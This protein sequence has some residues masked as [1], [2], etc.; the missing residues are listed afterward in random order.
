MTRYGHKKG[1]VATHTCCHADT[2]FIDLAEDVMRDELG[3]EPPHAYLGSN[4]LVFYTDCKI[5]N[6]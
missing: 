6:L 5:N 1:K 2:W 3:T 4:T